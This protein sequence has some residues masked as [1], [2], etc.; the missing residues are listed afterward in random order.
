MRGKQSYTERCCYAEVVT[1]QCLNVPTRLKQSYIETGSLSRR[2]DCGVSERT[3]DT[4]VELHR[5]G[6][7]IQK[8]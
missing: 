1:G 6:L 8:N 3:N 5:I 2:S 4:E 7:C